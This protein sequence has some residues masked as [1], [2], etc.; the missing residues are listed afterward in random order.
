MSIFSWLFTKPFPERAPASKWHVPLD[1]LS[2]PKVG[3][4][5]TAFYEDLPRNCFDCGVKTVEKGLEPMYIE[6]NLQYMKRVCY[7]PN[8]CGFTVWIA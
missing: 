5:C 1:W 4:S 3:Y 6:G 2:K 7:C 8:G